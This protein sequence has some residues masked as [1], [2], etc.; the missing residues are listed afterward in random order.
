M[1]SRTAFVLPNDTACVRERSACAA[2]GSFSAATPVLF[3]ITSSDQFTVDPYFFVYSLPVFG[4]ISSVPTPCTPSGPT[5]NTRPGGSKSL[6]ESKASKPSRVVGIVP[7]LCAQLVT[8]KLPA[9][10]AAI[11]MMLFM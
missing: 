4:T 7:Y 5:R 11:G 8:N 10:S 2:A 6:G 9:Q 1:Y 3:R